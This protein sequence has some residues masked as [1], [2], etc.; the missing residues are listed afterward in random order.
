[1]TGYTFIRGVADAVNSTLVEAIDDLSLLD[2][3]ERAENPA[4]IGD[5]PITSGHAYFS[6]MTNSDSTIKIPISG[7]NEHYLKIPIYLYYRYGDDLNSLENFQTT[8]NYMMDCVDL[9]TGSG[10]VLGGAHV[11]S[12]QN[13]VRVFA[14]ADRII[15]GVRVVLNARGYD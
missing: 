9:F 14:M 2:V 10:S 12:M 6:V 13:R 5:M 8:Q 4:I 1:M 11:Y 7:G 15:F 3:T